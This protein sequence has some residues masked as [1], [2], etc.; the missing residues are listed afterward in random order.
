MLTKLRIVNFKCLQDTGEL[1]IRPLTFLVGPNSSGK[2]SLLQL[3]LMLR[4]TV[5]S[6]DIENPLTPNDGWVKLGAYPDFIFG[7]DSRRKLEVHLYFQE[8]S[9]EGNLN[10]VFRFRYNQRTT[11]VRLE[12]S[13]LK[14]QFTD[15]LRQVN[16][17]GPLREL[18]QRSYLIS[19]QAP[20]D[21][22]TRGVPIPLSY[23]TPI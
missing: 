11:Q 14:L 1:D 22:G 17:L 15:E 16:Y 3:L 2:S 21:V 20:T 7:Q 9:S 12:S 19:G 23:G 5:D 10:A 13:E 18:P 6:M 4:Q 8:Q